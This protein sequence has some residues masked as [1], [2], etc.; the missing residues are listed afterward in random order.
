MPRRGVPLCCRKAKWLTLLT[1]SQCMMYVC[2]CTENTT[3]LSTRC[4]R[5]LGGRTI[6][7]NAKKHLRTRISTSVYQNTLVA[8]VR[9]NL[10]CTNH[11]TQD[12]VK[13][14]LVYFAIVPVSRITNKTRYA[15]AQ[16]H[17]KNVVTG[18]PDRS[19]ITFANHSIALTVTRRSST[20]MNAL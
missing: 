11:L 13:N 1:M 9:K 7:R 20:I 6:A 5:G 12:C 18:L 8:C 14:V 19:P 16:H 2:C 3:T 4:R 17:V 15:H 10:A